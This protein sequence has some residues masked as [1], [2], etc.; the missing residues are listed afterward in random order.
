MHWHTLS[1][2]NLKDKSLALLY[3]IV[4]NGFQ[5]GFR[6]VTGFNFNFSMTVFSLVQASVSGWEVQTTR[7]TVLC[8]WRTL[9]KVLMPCSVWLTNLLVADLLILIPLGYLLLG[10]G[11]SPM[12]L[13]FPAVM[14]IGTC[15]E[16][17][18]T[19]C[20]LSRGGEVERRESTTVWYL[21]QWMLIRQY[22]LECTQ[23][24]LVS[25]KC[26]KT[27]LAWFHPVDLFYRLY[28]PVLLLS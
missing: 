4:H 20:Y 10:T 26:N 17:E 2:E 8:P 3:R 16:Q 6:N 14:C 27:E 18:V 13:G 22:T 1:I 24:R 21:M 7:T 19:W 11:S 28:V 15:T 12:E 5:T 9:V 23:Q 25:G